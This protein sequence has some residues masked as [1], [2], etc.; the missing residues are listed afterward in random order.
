LRIDGGYSS[1]Q[2]DE[3]EPIEL[4]NAVNDFSGYRKRQ[5]E[6]IEKAKAG[7]K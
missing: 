7:N 5:N 6:A 1:Q 3:M 4:F 2:L